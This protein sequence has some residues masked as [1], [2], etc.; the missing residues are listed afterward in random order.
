MSFSGTEVTLDVPFLSL[1]E[2]TSNAE[3]EVKSEVNQLKKVLSS[4]DKLI[5]DLSEKLEDMQIDCV[6]FQTQIK[7]LESSKSENA[8]FRKSLSGWTDTL[9]LEHESNVA[10]QNE[11]DNKNEV[12]T[13]AAFISCM[14]LSFIMI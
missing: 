6:S 11:L 4:K 10:L 2:P 1:T 14:Y 13:Y 7:E 8:V 3:A 9:K 12:R 5:S